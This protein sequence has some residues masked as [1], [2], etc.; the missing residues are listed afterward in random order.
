MKQTTSLFLGAVILLGGSGLAGSAPAERKTVA[1]TL[2]VLEALAREVGGD[3]FEYFSLARA[4][5]N[6]HSV[7]A[8]PVLQRKLGRADLFLEIGLQLE[9]WADLV[10][11][12][13]GKPRL[14]RGGAGRIVVS[15][16]IPALEIPRNLTRAEGHVHPDGNP[17]LWLDPVRAKTMAKNIADAMR[18]ASPDRAE[19]IGDRLKSFQSRIDT[20][21]YG[22]ELVDLVGAGELDRLSMSGS[23]ISFLEKEE[24][25]GKKLI[26]RAGGWLAKCAPLRGRKVVEFHKIWIYATGFAGFEIAGSVEE[27]PG[28][29]P[30]PRHQVELTRMLKEEKVAFMLLSDYHSPALPH[31]L[32]EKT[33]C[34]TVIVPDQPGGT[35]GTADY[36]SFMDHVT[37]LM[38]DAVRKKE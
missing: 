25:D 7:R 12:H 11:N 23:L 21:L 29:P 10:A 38:V 8:T 36:F 20:A 1:C 24:M 19:A 26:E 37:D 6:P 32:S 28:I 13:A 9:M 35:D 18:K 3:D 15:D 33:G 2:P 4:A 22:K 30:G 5:Q 16:G 31:R 27:K 14:Q 17:H 34:P